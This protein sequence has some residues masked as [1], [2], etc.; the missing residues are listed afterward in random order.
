MEAKDLAK[1]LRKNVA[2]DCSELGRM[3]DINYF[4]VTLIRFAG[5]T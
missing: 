1:I 5:H 4:C 2:I 3:S